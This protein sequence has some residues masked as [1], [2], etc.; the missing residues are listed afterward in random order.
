[1]TSRSSRDG[2]SW[3]PNSSAYS[4]F[5]SESF[6]MSEAQRA[7]DA[8]DQDEL[9]SN[10]QYPQPTQSQYPHPQPSYGYPANDYPSISDHDL[11]ITSQPYPPPIPIAT[12]LQ[13][14]AA[15]AR[16]SNGESMRI[17][18][19]GAAGLPD[20]GPPQPQGT[21]G[22]SPEPPRPSVDATPT[23][24]TPG[25][26]KGK[27]GKASQACDECRRKKVREAPKLLW[28]SAANDDKTKCITSIDEDGIPTT[29]N[30]CAKAGIEC[31]YSRQPMKRGP[32]KGLVDSPGL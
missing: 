27:R 31:T 8:R 25:D 2:E 28:K 11:A 18:T 7:H 22:F 23:S 9:N 6:T 15:N 24:A 1:M 26:Q 30:S 29:C 13:D 10:P 4:H 12:Q 14:A 3:F 19:N 16:A 32:N 5:T 21:Q 20:M 17:N